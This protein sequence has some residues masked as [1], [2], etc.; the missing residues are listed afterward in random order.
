MDTARRTLLLQDP[1]GNI[2]MHSELILAPVTADF[3]VV[4]STQSNLPAS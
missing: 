3:N 4:S 1:E 2:T